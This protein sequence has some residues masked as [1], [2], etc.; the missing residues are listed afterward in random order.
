MKLNKL[1]AS[2]IAV[3]ALAFGSS[4]QAINVGGVVWDPNDPIFDFSATTNLFETIGLAVGDT[5]SG[6]G[7]VTSVNAPAHSA[8]PVS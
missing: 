8:R 7:Q 6:Y 4:A 2:L 5:F 1:A 3:S